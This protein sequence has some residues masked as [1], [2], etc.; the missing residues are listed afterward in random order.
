MSGDNIIDFRKAKAA[1]LSP[2]YSY[3]VRVEQH[4]DG[5]AGCILD[6]GEDLAPDMLR[7]VSEQ[8]FTLARY[9]MDQAFENGGNEGDCLLSTQLIFRDGRIR[10]WL[11]N[12]IANT[13]QLE[14]LRKSALDGIIDAGSDIPTAEKEP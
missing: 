8:L 3:H 4:V 2:E 9:I 6:L 14:W 10:T 7:L 12:E 11:S 13:A 1:R 5:V